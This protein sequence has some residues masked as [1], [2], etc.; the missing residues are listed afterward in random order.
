[1]YVD[2]EKN[3]LRVG[4]GVVLKSSKGVVFEHCPRLNFHATN[5]EAE[6]ES[7]IAGLRSAKKLLV[8]EL[9]ILSD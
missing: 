3:S 8:P 7:F 5:N 9:H 6:Y 1:M 4:A 2:G